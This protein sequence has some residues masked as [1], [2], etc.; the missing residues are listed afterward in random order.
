VNPVTDTVYIANDNN[1]VSAYK[2]TVGADGTFMNTTTITVGSDPTATAV[3][4][5]TNMVYV[6]NNGN[7]Q[8][9][10]GSVT[11]IDGATNTAV[12]TIPTGQDPVGIAVNPVT[13]MVFEVADTP[14]D[15]GNPA[16]KVQYLEV[17]KGATHTT[18]ASGFTTVELAPGG[19]S[20]PYAIAVNPVTNKIYVTDSNR[21]LYIVDGTQISTRTPA[22]AET[23]IYDTHTAVINGSTVYPQPRGL[24][25]NTVNNTIYVADGYTL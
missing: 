20:N 4:P 1:T 21:S 25:V 14:S 9:G 5:V 24:A 2:T 22:G 12:G 16:L 8:V 7:A 17:I 18:P 6:L 11:V 13:N 15:V 23:Y 19:Y 10:E 3:N